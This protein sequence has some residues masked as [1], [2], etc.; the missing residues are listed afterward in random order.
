LSG[1]FLSDRPKRPIKDD[2]MVE[3]AMKMMECESADARK[4]AR[5]GV[6]VCCILK[7]EEALSPAFLLDISAEGGFIKCEKRI[8]PGSQVT[9]LVDLPGQ[10][11]ASQLSIQAEV[12]HIG[13]FLQAYDN[14]TGFGVRFKSLSEDEKSKLQN[15]LLATQSQPVRKYNLF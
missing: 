14:F 9:L 4:S 10:D 13:R 3:R 8:H 5:N 6:A 11:S 7:F 1:I 12:V 2:R 15:A